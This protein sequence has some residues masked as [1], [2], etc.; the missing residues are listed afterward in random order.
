MAPKIN[1]NLMMLASTPEYFDKPEQTPNNILLFESLVSLDIRTPVF[2]E[3][4]NKRLYSR[5]ETPPRHAA[6]AS[7]FL[8]EPDPI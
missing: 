5:G 2:I 3:R 8:L 7:R 1:A 6:P 4:Q